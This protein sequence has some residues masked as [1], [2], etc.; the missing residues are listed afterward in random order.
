MG[1]EEL[2]DERLERADGVRRRQVEPR[3]PAVDH[4]LPAA[5]VDRRDQAIRADRSAKRAANAT[6]T[7]P[8]RTAPNRR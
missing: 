7:V 1:V 3:A 6:S 5:A 4:D 8:S 2:A